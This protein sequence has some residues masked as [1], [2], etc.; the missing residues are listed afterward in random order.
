[1]NGPSVMNGPIDLRSDTVTRP[2][3]AMY[4]AMCD[5]PLG[6]D[7]FG[8]DPTVKRLEERAAGLLGKEAALFVPSGTMGNAIAVAIHCRP[9]D[10][11]IVERTSHTYNFECGGSARL[12]GV[13]AVPV[14]SPEGNGR[15]PPA[16]IRAALRRDDVHLPRSRLVVL[17]QTHNLSGG[18]VLPLAYV[19]EVAAVCRSAGLA[20]HLDGARIFNAAVALGIAAAELARAADTVMF[21]VSKGLGAPAGSL[22][23]GPQ[24]L[25]KEA[26]RI[27]KLLGGGLRQ[28]GVLAAAGLHAIE[29]NIEAL[30]RDHEH[31][32][33]LG[34]ALAGIGGIRIR[35]WPVE[36]N[37]VYLDP[38]A[39]PS[40]AADRIGESLKGRGISA[41]KLGPSFRFV[42]HRD[43]DPLAAREARD[44]IRE[45]VLEALSRPSLK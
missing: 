23:C 11:M 19:E 4:R 28:V 20:L 9:G 24:A 14:D 5:A 40:D 25:I 26:R 10:E 2:D 21:C 43:I 17:E 22:L 6:D 44:R 31:A 33:A 34:E 18:R 36:T 39:E 38:P 1:M 27:R 41:V 16:A 13:Q 7:V 30:A 8:D 35:P 3:A 12:W 37:M 15:L 42:F 45:A 29:N 32:R